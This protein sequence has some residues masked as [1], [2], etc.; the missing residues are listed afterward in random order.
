MSPASPESVILARCSRSR[1][2]SLTLALSISPSSPHLAHQAPPAAAV[3]LAVA[4][5]HP[6][7]VTMSGSSS[8]GDAL[9]EHAYY[10]FEVI[11][12]ALD[13]SPEPA[14]QFDADE[15]L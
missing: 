11:Q 15:A 12:A 7:N 8:S 2:S 9:P 6:P 1:Q 10:C 13:G 14:P 4:G 5:P 3:L